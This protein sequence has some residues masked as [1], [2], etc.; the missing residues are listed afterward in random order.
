VDIDLDVMSSFKPSDIFK[1]CIP[2]SMVRDGE[3]KKHPCGIYFQNIPID[4][5][6]ELAAIPYEQAEEV[7]Y[8]K[9]DFL[10]LTLLEHFESKADIRALVNIEPNWELLKDPQ[11]VEKL[12]QIS[13]QYDIIKKLNIQSVNDLADTISLIR[14]GKIELLNE[15]LKNKQQVRK[16]LY[17]PPT[18]GKPYYKKSHSI[19]YALTIVLQ[20]HLI[21]GKI[22]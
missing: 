4:N 21:E 7:G 11:V 8:F 20:L 1:E 2:A 3:L 19:S 12:F 17:K 6:T 9:I 13:K 22:L 18:N 10:H 16:I 15:Y 14:P 5:L